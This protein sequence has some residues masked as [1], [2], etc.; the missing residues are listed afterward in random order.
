[1][2]TAWEAEK[3]ML[4]PRVRCLQVAVASFCLFI[5][6]SAYPW[7][8]GIKKNQPN[9]DFSPRSKMTVRWH[10][11]I[12]IESCVCL[13]F[14]RWGRFG[15]CEDAFR[16]SRF[17]SRFHFWKPVLYQLAVSARAAG[18]GSAIQPCRPFQ[19]VKARWIQRNVLELQVQMSHWKP[20][21]LRLVRPWPVLWQRSLVSA[22]DASDD[23]WNS[24]EDFWWRL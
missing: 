19:G 5:N 17:H 10:A 14:C 4:L 7:F 18:R 11:K 8:T 2:A 6:R 1:M 3:G 13:Q 20:K 21:K 12:Q 15:F 23:L 22:S 16:V 24:L 9:A